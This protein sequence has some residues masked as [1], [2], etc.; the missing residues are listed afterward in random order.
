MAAPSTSS[1]F[2]PSIRTTLLGTLLLLIQSPS[3]LA[4]PHPA[5]APA[6]QQWT[7]TG[8]VGTNGNNWASGANTGSN[9]GGPWNNGN[10]NNHQWNNNNN[11][12]GPT[13][14]TPN[15]DGQWQP[16]YNWDGG[17]FDPRIGASFCAYF[18]SQC[19]SYTR[20]LTTNGDSSYSD[21]CPRPI[22]DTSSSLLPNRSGC[23]VTGSDDDWAQCVWECCDVT[24]DVGLGVQEFPPTARA[25]LGGVWNPVTGGWQG[26]R[27]VKKV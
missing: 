16:G 10:W 1:Q 12:Q 19:T 17:A 21:S 20:S 25:K 18:T 9:S 23:H 5:P 11:N 27:R 2:H 26:R 13:R 4:L 14:N 6:A 3:S 8:S 24:L 7:D 22:D 15:G